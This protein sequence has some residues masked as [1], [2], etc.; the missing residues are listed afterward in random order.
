MDG[1]GSVLVVAGGK[2]VDFRVGGNDPET[3]VLALEGL[4]GGPLVQVPDADGLV[5]AGGQDEVLM[6]VEQAAAGVLEVAPAS[7]NL[8]LAAC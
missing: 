3:V 2:E 6:R 5:L 8:P 7:I 4:D 1:R